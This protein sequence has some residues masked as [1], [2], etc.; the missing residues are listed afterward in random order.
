MI[1]Q[2]RLKELFNYDPLTGVLTNRIAR[3]NN[4][5]VGDTAGSLD[6][7][8]H[9]RSNGYWR[10]S[11]DGKRHYSHRL[12]WLIAYGNAVDSG[13]EIDHINGDTSDNRL[14]NLRLST[15]SENGQN[16]QMRTNN[17]SGYKGVCWESSREKWLAT[18][19]INGKNH[20]IGRFDSK[21]DA[22]AAHSSFAEA[23]QKEFYRP[24]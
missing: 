11:V 10:V 8:H 18:C 12:I 9:G 2:T 7:S 23:H 6:L 21:A 15:P 3:S 5:K 22:I 19:Q 17:K 16:Q 24:S 20:R 13:L 1:T 14:S 4:N